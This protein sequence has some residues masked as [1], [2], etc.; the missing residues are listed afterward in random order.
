MNESRSCRLMATATTN[1]MTSS[2]K[3][4]S[5]SLFTNN[6]SGGLLA[7]LLAPP[8]PP[9]LPPRLV[10]PTLGH[11]LARERGGRKIVI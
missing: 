3:W 4:L 2:C 8:L 6:S 1:R 10:P 9:P 11:D 7:T 5:G